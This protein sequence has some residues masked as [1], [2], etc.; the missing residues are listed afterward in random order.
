MTQMSLLADV[1]RVER[2]HKT[3]RRTSREAFLE[4]EPARGTRKDI[5]GRALRYLWNVGQ[6]SATAKQIARWIVKRGV[7]WPGRCPDCT[8]YDV[9]RGLDDLR[10]AGVAD[11][12]DDKVGKE[13]L[14]RWRE[15]GTGER[16]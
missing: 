15:Q 1:I 3:A 10:R 5:V 7:D 6:R 13:L 12:K 9:R 14:W 16:R 11:T 2:P 4:N 8:L